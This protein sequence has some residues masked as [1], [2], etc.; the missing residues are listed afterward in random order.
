ME[1]SWLFQ[2]W[3][4][5]QARVDY[6]GEYNLHKARFDKQKWWDHGMYNDDLTIDDSMDGIGYRSNKPK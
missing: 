3:M 6:T 4:F 2:W 1:K 5:Q